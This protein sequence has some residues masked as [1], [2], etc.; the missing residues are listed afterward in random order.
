MPLLPAFLTRLID[1]SCAIRTSGGQVSSCQRAYTRV[2]PLGL[3]DTR[4]CFSH[5]IA[6]VAPHDPNI[7]SLRQCHAMLRPRTFVRGNEIFG[8]NERPAP[9]VTHGRAIHFPAP[10]KCEWPLSPSG[11]LYR[12]L[13]FE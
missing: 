3:G 4:A 7:H 9:L 5:R 1:K 11:H 2:P 8:K 12:S 13:A 10:R 6:K